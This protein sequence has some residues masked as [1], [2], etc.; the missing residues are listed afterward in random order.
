MATRPERRLTYEDY[1]TFPEGERW[2]VIDGEAY[3]VPAPNTRHQQIIVE[4]LVQVAN[5]LKAHGGG[6]VLVSP[7]DVVLDAGGD[8]VQPDIVFIADADKDVLT[9]ANAWGTP[10]W[11]IE[12][13]SP[14]RPER[15]RRLKLGRYEN[16]GVAEYWIVDPMA[17]A[18]E[19]YRLEA[20]TYGSPS[21]VRPP[22][23]AS[24]LQPRG[25]AVDLAEVFRRTL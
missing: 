6:T 3:M 14:S 19:I 24:P 1:L 10:T 8:V 5:H 25:L 9:E 17:D 16:F 15:D 11:V 4:I 13:L 2:E 22:D 21:I 20:G 23:T 12:V 18:V 7:F